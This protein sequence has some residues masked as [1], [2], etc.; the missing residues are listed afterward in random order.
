M[1]LYEYEVKR[2]PSET[3]TGVLEADSQQAA[4][5]RLRE[6]GYHPL[7]VAERKQD[8]AGNGPA[9]RRFHKIRQRDVNLF[10]RQL[11]NL[12][13]AGLPLLRAL[14]TLIT[15]TENPKMAEVMRQIR[16]GVQKGRTLAECLA[17][18]PKVFP[19]MYPNMVRAGETGGMLE[20]VLL[21]IA[22]FGEKSENLRNKVIGALIYPAFLVVVGFTALFVLISFV[23]PKL[24]TFF[25]GLNAPLPVATRIVM[26][27]CSFMSAW[28]WLILG[29]IAF[30]IFAVRRYVATSR[31]R[32][33]VDKGLLK[34]PVFGPVVQ[35][36]EISK[37]TRTL[38]TLIDNGVPILSALRIVVDTLTNR[39]LAQEVDSIHDDISEGESLNEALRRRE[40]FPLS[41][42]NVLAIGEESGKLGEACN[43]I[44]DVYDGEVDRAV[45]AMT[46]LLEPA[47]I[48]VMAFFVGFL[49]IAMLL[50]IFNVSSYIQ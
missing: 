13:N 42:V 47:L 49:V 2:N 1:P 22:A 24:M 8:V 21:R 6:M 48:I 28:W 34:A 3:V 17:D 35:R 14:N 41:V 40:H 23:F 4:V 26:A 18:H 32:F 39:A 5:N 30:V 16:A 33:Q 44:A 25:D 15:E 29:S 37:F 50:P 45:S 36:V 12:T 10:F 7:A 11:A 19:A 31:G 43:R 20:E 9:V 46:S 38:G 27:I